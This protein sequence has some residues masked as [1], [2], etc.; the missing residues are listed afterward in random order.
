[1]SYPIASFM[2]ALR[3][4]LAHAGMTSDDIVASEKAG[5]DALIASAQ[6][7]KEG[8]WDLLKSWGLKITGEAGDLFFEVELPPGWSKQATS[9][10]MNSWLVDDKG[11]RRANIFYKAA[12]YDT[13][14][15]ITPIERRFTSG[16]D[17]GSEDYSKDVIRCV[18]TDRARDKTLF[19]GSPVRYGFLTKNPKELGAIK[20][21]L[22][23]FCTKKGKEYA[24]ERFTKSVADTLATLLTAD[25]FCQQYHY[26]VPRHDVIR[27][28]ENLA[29]EGM[30]QKI[31]EMLADRDQWEID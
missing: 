4:D 1:M 9:H 25:V 7:P 24:C 26:V 14:A 16:K 10:D 28:A 22:F 15:E 11:R 21:G 23:Y 30:D 13:K 20:D 8:N 17:Y 2:A 5:R 31:V 6:L 3:G 29:A 18:I 19:V 27:A 12:Y